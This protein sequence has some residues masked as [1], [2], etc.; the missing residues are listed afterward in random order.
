MNPLY[1]I[2]KGLDLRLKG[3]AA[4][5]LERLPL[6]DVYAV[7]PDNFEGISPR[8]LV[9]EGDSVKAGTPLFVDK[10]T[11]RVN[12]VAPVSGTVKAIVRGER[13]KLLRIEIE[14]NNAVEFETYSRLSE[15][16]TAEEVKDT[17]LKSG[18][19]AFIKQRPYDVVAIPTEQPKAI[20]VSAF[21]KMPLAANFSYVAE[22]QE[23][24]FKAGIALLAKI[25]QVHVGI[26]P[27]QINTDLLPMHEAQV[28]VFAGP[29]PSGNVGVHINHVSPINK[30]EVVWTVGA[31]VVIF[32]GRFA[33]TGQ[34]NLTRRIAV[35]GSQVT[36][37]HYVET[38]IGTPLKTVLAQNIKE[39]DKHQRIINGNPLVGVKAE[40]DDYLGAF[41]TEVC[42]IPEGDDVNE[43][44][45][46]I[47]PR[48]N[49]FST[50]RSYLSWLFGK[51]KKYD[52][53]CRIKGGERHIIMS[54]EYDRVFPMDIF[55]GY[56]IKAIITGDI[57]RQ[58]ALGI[59]EV[60]P[61]DFAVAEFV[62]SSKLDLQRIVREGLD[63]LRG[64]N[65]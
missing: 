9:K 41:N 8:L 27:E 32:F 46:W 2:K 6:S 23:E 56:L 50:N 55:A 54:G 60:A 28:S 29:N 42:V 12:V 11:G 25:A 13:R 1:K 4:Q 3:E 31:E 44:F 40:K 57:D 22:K 37:P 33:R 21:S 43:L 24:D 38:F 39:S 45:G 61:E 65:A 49:E 19:F 64:E 14:T 53:D 10:A 35:A 15:N 51:N 16:A 59:Y 7:V 48:P 20:F 47:M 5:T 52:L 63:I 30:G 36:T 34:V 62:D 58:E 17:L 18:L 26:S